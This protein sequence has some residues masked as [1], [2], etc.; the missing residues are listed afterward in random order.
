MKLLRVSLLATAVMFQAQGAAAADADRGEMLYGSRCGA[1]H[2]LDRNRIGPMHRGVFGREAGTA[3]DFDYSDALQDSTV[4]WDEA[5]LDTWLANP[6]AFIPGQ[7]MFFSLRK[8]DE[9][10]DIIA[11]LQRESGQ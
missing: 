2:S 6:Q 3:T 5:S 10:A 1:C 7:K 4:V 8:A 11:F 9:R